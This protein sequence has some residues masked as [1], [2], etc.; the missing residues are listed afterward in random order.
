MT[1]DELDRQKATFMDPGQWTLIDSTEDKLFYYEGPEDSDAVIQSVMALVSDVTAP[2]SKVPTWSVT[3]GVP[4][5]GEPYHVDV[6]RIVVDTPS[7]ALTKALGL[8]FAAEERG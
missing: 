7:L 8:L 6:P 3:L 4:W 5:L 1:A 2:P